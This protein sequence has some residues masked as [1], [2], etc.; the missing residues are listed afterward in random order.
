MSIDRGREDGGWM[1]RQIEFRVPEGERDC[2]MCQKICA[3]VY[4]YIM[5]ALACNEHGGEG[6]VR[7]RLLTSCFAVRQ[8]GWSRCDLWSWQGCKTHPFPVGSQTPVPTITHLSS[9]G[10]ALVAVSG[11]LAGVRTQRHI[12]DN[13]LPC[14]IA[15]LPLSAQWMRSQWN[16]PNN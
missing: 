4:I 8:R 12:P 16:W 2:Q 14:I 15:I 7:R 6:G 3:H 1:G 13:H 10:S 5:C 9:S 11:N